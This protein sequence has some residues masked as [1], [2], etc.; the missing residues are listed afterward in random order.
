M[1]TFVYVMA[2]LS[3]YTALARQSFSFS[4]TKLTLNDFKSWNV[5]TP[6]ILALVSLFSP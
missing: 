5:S 1:L 2:S 4:T 3:A 6:I